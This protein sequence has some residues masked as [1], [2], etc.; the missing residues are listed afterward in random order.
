[1]AVCADWWLLTEVLF[2]MSK[3]FPSVLHIQDSQPWMQAVLHPILYHSRDRDNMGSKILWQR[4]RWVENWF[5]CF[6]PSISIKRWLFVHECGCQFSTESHTIW[7]TVI[8]FGMED[9]IY[10]GE[11]LGYISFRYPYPQGWGP[12]TWITESVPPKRCISGKIS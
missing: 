9:P 1:M 7:Q 11:V 2:Y 12:K 4:S 10:P 8:K 3:I 6:G 5:W